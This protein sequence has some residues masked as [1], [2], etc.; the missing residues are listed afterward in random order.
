MEVTELP[1]VQEDD[2]V[3]RELGWSDNTLSVDVVDIYLW[4]SVRRKKDGQ[5]GKFEKP[6][7]WAR[8]A[9]DGEQGVSGDRGPSGIPAI[10]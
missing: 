7:C 1:A 6:S 3:P 2:Y 9:K 4:C 8:Y 10:E 5:W